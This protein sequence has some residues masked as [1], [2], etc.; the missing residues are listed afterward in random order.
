MCLMKNNV[1]IKINRDENNP[2]EFLAVNVV[3]RD[4]R[5]FGKKVWQQKGWVRSYFS[6]SFRGKIDKHILNNIE[7]PVD[8]IISVANHFEPNASI[9][10]YKKAVVAIKEWCQDA[11]NITTRDFDGCPFKHTYYFPAEQYNPDQ[12]FQ[13][14]DHCRKGYGEVEIHLHH[15]LEEPDNSGHLREQLEE[16]KE[17]LRLHGFLSYDVFDT[18]KRSRYCFVHGNWALANSAR[19]RFCGVDNEMEVLAETGCYMDCTFPCAPHEAQVNKINSIYECGY[20]LSQPK[21]HRDG[22]DL[23]VGSR[24]PI[25]PFLLQGPLLINWNFDKNRRCFPSIENGAINDYRPPT[26]ERFRLWASANIHVG[27]RRNWIFIKLHTHGLQNDHVNSV[28]GPV[29]KKFLQD[30]NNLFNDGIKYRLHFTTSRESA[31]II[32]AAID[33]NNGNPDEY[34]NYRFKVSDS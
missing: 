26:I 14:E 8:F 19:G 22:K 13:L 23:A 16:F 29:I 25:F 34:R 11:E 20:P 10:G 4:L 33:G 30:L 28:R 24:E 17:K 31:N 15:G 21:P 3:T 1:C 32:F 6:Q 12:L 7:P 2:K 5:N 27:G 18:D 9:I